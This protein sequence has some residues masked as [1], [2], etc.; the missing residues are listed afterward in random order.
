[1][2]EG[3][4]DM[5]LDLIDFDPETKRYAV[6]REIVEAMHR[7]DVAGWCRHARERRPQALQACRLNTP[8]LPVEAAAAD[9]SPIRDPRPYS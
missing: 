6:I 5:R 2:D 8:A 4:G 3:S 9:A 7:E 1:M